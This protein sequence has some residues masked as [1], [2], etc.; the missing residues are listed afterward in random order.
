MTKYCQDNGIFVLP[1]LSP[2][3]PPGTSRLRANVTAAHTIADIDYALEVFE[4]AGKL[5]GII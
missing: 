1:V 2:A 5:V 3:V 4:G